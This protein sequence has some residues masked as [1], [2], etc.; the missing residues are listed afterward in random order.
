MRELDEEL[1]DVKMKIIDKETT[2]TIRMSSLIL[3]R[4]AMLL[5]VER[6][7]SSLDAAISLALTA[8]Q[9]GSGGDSTRIKVFTGPNACGK[10]IYLKQEVGLSLLAST[11]SYWAAKGQ[12]GCPHV[13]VSSHFHA[14]PNFVT[15]EQDVVSYHTMEVRCRGAELD[16]QYR[17]VDGVVDSSYAAYIACKMGIPYDVGDRAKQVYE[18]VRKGHGIGDLIIDSEEEQKNRWLA[19]RMLEVLPQ[20]EKWDIDNDLSGL[21]DLLQETLFKANEISTRKRGLREGS[22]DFRWPYGGVFP[23]A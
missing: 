6:V 3:S 12:T 5:G 9:L 10:S 13:F 8:R 4:S 7:A 20:F 2:I 1:G 16:F 17:L 14:L 19:K 23:R 18:H 11:I 21:L 15:D 22:V